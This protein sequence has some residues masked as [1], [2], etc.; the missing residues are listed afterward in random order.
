M[1]EEIPALFTLLMKRSPIE[2]Q[3]FGERRREMKKGAEERIVRGEKGEWKLEYWKGG[4]KIDELN[5]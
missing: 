4:K 2:R 3:K 1:P 5:I